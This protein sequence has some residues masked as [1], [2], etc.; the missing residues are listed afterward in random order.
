MRVYYRDPDENPTDWELIVVFVIIVLVW[1]G[2]I[3]FLD[4][5]TFDAVV[6]WAEPFTLFLL[7]P[8]LL[9][10]AEYGAN[11]LTWWPLVWGTKVSIEGND[12]M[13]VWNKEDALK[14]FGGP[15][16]VYYNHDYI[17]FRRR[18]DAVTYCLF[19][20]TY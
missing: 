19:Q 6:W 4:W 9:L 13:T 11:P 1:W 15:L 18:A 7:I 14:K 20:K 10:W 3:H 12:F 17:K 16:N 8:F 2:I 5:L